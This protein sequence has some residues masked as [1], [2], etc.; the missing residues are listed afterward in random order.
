[1]GTFVSL[2]LSNYLSIPQSGQTRSTSPARSTAASL[3][4]KAPAS[5]F[6][7]RLAALGPAPEV[8]GQRSE[9]M[10]APHVNL[11]WYIK[12]EVALHE[13][14]Q[15]IPPGTLHRYQKILDLNPDVFQKG[16][17]VSVFMGGK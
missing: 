17:W 16:R 15:Q 12:E 5:S 13:G 14:M 10:V 7:T 8:T 3:A 2:T 6:A 9:R 11:T 1:M 4:K